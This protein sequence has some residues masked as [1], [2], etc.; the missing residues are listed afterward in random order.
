MNG[1]IGDEV[2]PVN[3]I[4]ARRLVGA[5]EVSDHHTLSPE[6]LSCGGKN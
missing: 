6:D 1:F 2:E 4:D 3:C 5:S